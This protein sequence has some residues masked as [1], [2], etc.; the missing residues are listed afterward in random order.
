MLNARLAELKAAEAA[1]LTDAPQAEASSPSEAIHTADVAAAAPIPGPTVTD[2]HESA[3]LASLEQMGARPFPPPDEGTAVIFSPRPEFEFL[4]EFAP[5]PAA[6]AETAPAPEQAAAPLSATESAAIEQTVLAQTAAE[7]QHAPPHAIEPEPAPAET[8]MAQI[9][10]DL[11]RATAPAPALPAAAEIAAPD[12]EPTTRIEPAAEPTAAMVTSDAM[13]AAE[14]T[15]SDFDP[16]D[17]LF[18]PEPEPDPAAFL[19]DPAPPAPASKA[20]VRAQ[21]DFVAPPAKPAA[22]NPEPLP[23]SE[24]DPPAQKGS[25]PAPHDPLRALKAMSE[26]EKLALFS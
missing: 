19:L 6:P 1:H 16:A 18:E 15:E 11:A 10:S 25:E 23:P 4:P 12:A 5:E 24:S 26:N 17:F 14:T 20:A 13:A 21:P 8:T 7:S 3:L 9:L 22:K 2:L